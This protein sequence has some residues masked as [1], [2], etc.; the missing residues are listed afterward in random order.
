MTRPPAWRV[1]VW[2]TRPAPRILFQHQLAACGVVVRVVRP[3]RPYR[4]GFALAARLA[5]PDLVDQ[6]VTIVFGPGNSTVPH[7]YTNGPSESPH[8]YFDGSLCMWYPDDPDEQRWTFRDGPA[9]LLGHIVAHLMR[10]EWWRR[11]GEWPGTEAEH[12]VIRSGV[13]EA[14]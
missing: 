14:A 2:H 7:V 8:R 12:L 3:P 13:Q 6:A 10:E 9:V 1:P 5:L 11:T 4:G